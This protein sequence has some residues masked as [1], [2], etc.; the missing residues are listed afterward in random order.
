VTLRPGTD[1]DPDALRDFCRE[2][3]AHFKVPRYVKVVSE[4]P[5]TVTGKVQ[6]FRIREAAIVELGLDET[7]TLRP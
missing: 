5:M 4:F 1:L 7:P 3:I 2:R 6:K